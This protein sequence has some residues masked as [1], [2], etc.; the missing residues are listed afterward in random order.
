M[1]DRIFASFSY[2]TYPYRA[3]TGLSPPGISITPTDP[4]S[5]KFETRRYDDWGLGTGDKGSGSYAGATSEASRRYE[6]FQTPY[7]IHCPVMSMV[8]YKKISSPLYTVRQVKAVN[9]A[10]FI[11]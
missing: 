3:A 10:V 2:S 9:N 4:Q 1:A 8:L 7:I 5:H 11:R 6:T